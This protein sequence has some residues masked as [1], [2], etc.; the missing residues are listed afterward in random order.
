MRRRNICL[1]IS[2]AFIGCTFAAAARAQIG[3]VFYIDMENHNLTQPSGLTSPQQI[4][5]NSAAPY[6]NNLMTPGNANAAQISWASDYQN[7]GVGIHPSLPNYL[8]QEAGTN[9]GV[10]NDNMPFGPGGNNQGNAPNLS[11]LMQAAGQAWSNCS[12]WGDH[13]LSA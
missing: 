12:T 2:T 8:F 13:G 11:G 9:F 3:D 1:L 6:I 10:T 4:M 5:G 7:V